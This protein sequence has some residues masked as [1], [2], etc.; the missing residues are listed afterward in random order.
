MERFDV[1]EARALVTGANRGIGKEICEALIGAGAKKVYAAV[2]DPESARPLVEKHGDMVVPVE[3]D[4]TDNDLI[5]TAAAC[6]TDVELVVNNGGVLKTASVLA[7]R[8]LDAIRV[9]VDVNVYGLLR[10]VQA[11]APVLEKNGGGAF[12]Q[13]NSVVSM[14]CF[15]DFATYCAS[16]AAAY[17]LTQ[18]MRAD[19]ARQGTQVYSIH[20]GPIDTDMGA[21]AGLSEMAESPAKVAQAMLQAF[22]TGS[23]HVWPD[24]MAEQLGGAYRSFAADVVEAQMSPAH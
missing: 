1:R 15:P 18:A 14:K 21:S 12:V 3:F 5:S 11:F 9:E 6:A 16:K 10:T 8:A 4:L 22:E 17:S 19:L 24:S 23:F 2:R 7:D 13:I 20:P